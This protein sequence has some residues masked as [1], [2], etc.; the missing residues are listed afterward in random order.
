MIS[1]LYH[2]SLIFLLFILRKRFVAQGNALAFVPQ[3]GNPVLNERVFLVSVLCEILNVYCLVKYKKG[4]L[5][6]RSSVLAKHLKSLL[7][8][9]SF[10]GGQACV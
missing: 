8:L 5:S 3:F 7:H 1:S 4:D 9:V 2:I 10:P 6:L